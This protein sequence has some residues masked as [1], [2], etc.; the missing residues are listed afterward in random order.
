MT[1][2]GLVELPVFFDKEYHSLGRVGGAQRGHESAVFRKLDDERRR[3]LG[4]RRRQKNPI[5]RRMRGPPQA[6]ITPAQMHPIPKIVK[7]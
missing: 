5:I 1:V 3:E 2:L 6:P 7:E 4:R